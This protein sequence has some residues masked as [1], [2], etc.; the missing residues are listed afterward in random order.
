[1]RQLRFFQENVR[2]RDIS[3]SRAPRSRLLPFSLLL[4]A[5]VLGPWTTTAQVV[6]INPRP[7][8]PQER[9]SYPGTTQLS[10]G[11][12][13]SGI[14]TPLYLEALVTKGTV[15]TQVTWTLLSNPPGSAATLPQ[16]NP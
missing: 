13:N 3:N 2:A 7:L 12:V 8:T 9:K 16:T 5:V 6:K 14:G 11:R 10:G 15:V 4:A 1:M